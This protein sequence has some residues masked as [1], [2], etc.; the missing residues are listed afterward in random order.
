[1]KA[2]FKPH[3]VILYAGDRYE[4]LENHGESGTVKALDDGGVIVTS[5]RWEY[6]GERCVREGKSSMTMGLKKDDKILRIMPP[7]SGWPAQVQEGRV[8]EVTED[9]Y[10]CDIEADVPRMMD[11]HIK[12]GQAIGEVSSFIIRA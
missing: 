12:D 5:F 1:M 10:R 9:R 11:F 7:S 8:T 6:E 4:V 2:D 3:E